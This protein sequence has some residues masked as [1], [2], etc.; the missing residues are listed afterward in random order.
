M[1]V[2]VVSPHLD[3]GVFSVGASIRALSRTGH[4]V[5]VVTIFAND[6]GSSGPVGDWD[7]SCGFETRAEAALERR[8]EDQRACELLGG[9]THWLPYPASENRSGVVRSEL[10]KTLRSSLSHGLVLTPMWPLTHPDHLLTTELVLATVRPRSRIVGYVEQPYASLQL[11]A[12]IR[13]RS[14]HQ[15][16]FMGGEGYTIR[17][18]AGDWLKKCQAVSQYQSQLRSLR[19]L[20]RARILSYEALLGGET[21]RRI[22]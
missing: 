2:T 13:G 21:L 8:R 12:R 10:A 9:D 3:D 6:P 17:T 22:D 18:S 4:T 14:P 11:L 15:V 20:P 7:R 5:R 16:A 1:D 19:P